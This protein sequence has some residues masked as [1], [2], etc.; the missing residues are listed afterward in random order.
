MERAAEGMDESLAYPSR[1][2]G[3]RVLQVLRYRSSR[4]IG[5]RKLVR[6]RPEAAITA[7]GVPTAADTTDAPVRLL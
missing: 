7:R 1:P 6:V 4:Q 2:P 3:E 5:M